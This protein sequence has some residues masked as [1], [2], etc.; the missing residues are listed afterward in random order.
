MTVAI[1]RQVD[2]KWSLESP[3]LEVIVDPA[4]GAEVVSLMDRQTQTQI[5]WQHPDRDF[6]LAGCGTSE[7]KFFDHYAGGIQELFPNA[8]PSAVVDGAELLFHGESAAIGWSS[9]VVGNGAEIQLRCWTRLRR[10]PFALEKTFTLSAS[11]STLTIDST[12]TNLSVRAMPVHWGLHPTFSSSVVSEATI[13][14]IFGDGRA[15]PAPF[16]SRQVFEPGEVVPAHREGVLTTLGLT[17][18]HSGT[19][20][21][22]YLPFHEGWYVVGHSAGSVYV[23]LTWPIEKFPNVWLWQQCHEPSGYPWW[24]RH[25][26]V[27]I[28]PHTSA[29]SMGLDEEIRDGCA[30]MVAGEKTEHA[31]FVLHVSSGEQSLESFINVVRS[32]GT[33]SRTGDF[34]EAQ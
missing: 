3:L 24:G 11:S 15:D 19:A 17:P 6:T 34:P 22:V 7:A 5:L 12:I 20:D 27:G 9:E 2:G 31:Q 10:Y 25:H 26:I 13:T 30:F 32:S 33:E 16:G 8:G 18:E 14:G 21:L 1:T 4:Y 28:E 23:G 29:P